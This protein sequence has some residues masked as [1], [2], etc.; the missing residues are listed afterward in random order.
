M[1]FTIIR[2]GSLVNITLIYGIVDGIEAIDTD[3]DNGV[4]RWAES[5]PTKSEIRARGTHGTCMG[6]DLR[7]SWLL[8][9]RNNHLPYLARRGMAMIRTPT[10]S[11]D[12]CICAEISFHPL[13]ECV[14][15]I[16]ER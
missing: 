5:Y 14:S 7:S 1:L 6:V 9:L 13:K 2:E 10:M 12:S 16:K 15:A 8:F 4:G 3:V 11:L